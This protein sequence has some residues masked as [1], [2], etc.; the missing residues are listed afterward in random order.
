M[1]IED[2]A[3]RPAPVAFPAGRYRLDP[4]HST[5]AFAA[6][7]LSL[8]T[9]RGTMGIASGEFVVGTPLERSRV[10]VVVSAGTFATPMAKRDEHVKG[11]TLLDVETYPHIE[12][13]STEVVPGSGAWEIRGT[14]TIHGQSA[15]A[16]LSVTTTAVEDTGLVRV[17]AQ[18]DVDRRLFGV[19][20]KRL[21]VSPVLSVRIE[22][23]GVPLR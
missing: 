13:T 10:H 7:K 23:V 6:K 4:H 11:S 18:T 20:A 22:A 21:V 8:F 12:F 15:P 14:L 17:S 5:V 1:T 16:T 19:S 2:I 3:Q 9:V